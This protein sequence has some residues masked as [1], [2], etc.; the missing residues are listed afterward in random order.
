M[1]FVAT[2]KQAPGIRDAL[3]AA[4]SRVVEESGN[5]AKAAKRLGIEQSSVSEIIGKKRMARLDTLVAIRNA[6][7]VSLDD[8]L[9]LPP[10]GTPE[11][12]V[13]APLPEVLAYYAG[14]WDGLPLDLT[15]LAAREGVPHVGWKKTLDEMAEMLEPARKPAQAS[16]LATPSGRTGSRSTRGV[17]KSGR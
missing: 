10:V 5:Q 17:R 11:P 15:T 4:V 7:G 1:L 9:R 6:L 8:L 2:Q 14:R 13:D 12:P 16:R 3:A